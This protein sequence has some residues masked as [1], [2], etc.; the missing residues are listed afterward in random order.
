MRIIN[1]A[2]TCSKVWTCSEHGIVENFYYY[3]RPSIWEIVHC[4]VKNKIYNFSCILQ[5][6]IMCSWTLNYGY[7]HTR[8]SINSLNRAVAGGKLVFESSTKNFL[9]SD[10]RSFRPICFILFLFYC[11]YIFVPLLSIAIFCC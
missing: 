6:Y 10:K 3:F 7:A 5:W 1:T 2:A 4:F 8:K 9:I 11:S